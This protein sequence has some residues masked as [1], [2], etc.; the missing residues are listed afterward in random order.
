[1]L[2]W[3]GENAKH[4]K[5]EIH[6]L[7]FSK[8]YMV[9][10]QIF[11]YNTI[12]TCYTLHIFIYNTYN[13]IP[14]VICDHYPCDSIWARVGGKTCLTFVLIV[15][16][17]SERVQVGDWHFALSTYLYTLYGKGKVIAEWPDVFKF[18]TKYSG[19]SALIRFG[20]P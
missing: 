20:N 3:P 13:C 8:I 19:Q 2:F 1:M 14:I 15:C 4:K 16:S 7:V 11:F 18:C 6:Y 12:S 10:V 17:I 9:K 5:F